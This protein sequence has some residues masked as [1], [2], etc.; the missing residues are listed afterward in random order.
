MRR[1]YWFAALVLVG[2]AACLPALAGN[3]LP[4]LYQGTIEEVSG[5]PG[6]AGEDC[7]VRI[8]AAAK[9]GGSTS[10]SVNDLDRFLFEDAKVDKLLESGQKGIKLLSPP[11]AQGGDIEIVVMTLDD[12]RWPLTVKMLRKNDYAHKQEKSIVCEGLVRK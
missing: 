11:Q 3:R 1:T 6:R 2:N 8:A 7:V 12:E 5:Y 9:Y 10:F 4:G